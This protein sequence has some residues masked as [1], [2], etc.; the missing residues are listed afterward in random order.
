[1]CR[2]VWMRSPLDQ[3][4]DEE[5]STNTK[6]S[7]HVELQTTASSKQHIRTHK[8]PASP[9]ADDVG[10]LSRRRRPLGLD[11]ERAQLVSGGHEERIDVEEDK[12]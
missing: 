12:G 11:G 5:W 10:I 3:T 1:M 6:A 2:R 7:L 9:T 8:V 4:R